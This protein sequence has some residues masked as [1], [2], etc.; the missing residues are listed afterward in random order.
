MISIIKTKKG[1][2]PLEAVSSRVKNFFE[3]YKA[4]LKH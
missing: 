3:F 1:A 2:L 4:N